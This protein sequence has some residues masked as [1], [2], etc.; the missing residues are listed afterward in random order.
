MKTHK[1]RPA[2]P[3][4]ESHARLNDATAGCRSEYISSGVSCDSGPT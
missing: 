3:I 2:E 1:R 4:I